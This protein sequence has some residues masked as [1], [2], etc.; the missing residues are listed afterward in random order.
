LLNRSSLQVR[1]ATTQPKRFWKAVTVDKKP[2]GY[3][4]LLDSRPLKTP[5][6]RVITMPSSGIAHCVA[7][8]WSIQ[9]Q[10]GPLRPNDLLI[11]SRSHLNTLPHDEDVVNV[12]ISGFC[13][14]GKSFYDIV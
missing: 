13:R 14:A 6:G 3:Q 7:A 10:D 11:V 2:E 5:D 4:V 8:E 12:A 1:F 9:D